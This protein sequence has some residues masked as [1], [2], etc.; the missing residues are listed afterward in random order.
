MVSQETVEARLKSFLG[1]LQA[2]YGILDRIVYKNKNQHRRCSYFQYLLKVRSDLRL[3]Q[4]AHLEEIVSSSFIV[5]NGNRAKQK[6]Q[7]LESLK[8]KKC[9]GKHNFLERLLGATRLVAEMVEP[10]MKAATEISILLARSFFMSFSVTVLALLGRLRV[11]VQQILLDV[12]SVFNTVST[13]SQ[14]AQSVKLSQE[15]FEVYREY[16]PT[17]EQTVTLD[18]VL[19]T[20][21]FVLLER[22]NEPS[23]KDSD[24]DTREEVSLGRPAVQYQSIETVL[25]DDLSKPSEEN[26]ANLK[27]DDTTTTTA[28]N[29]SSLEATVPQSDDSKQKDED[30]YKVENNSGLRIGPPGPE[31]NWMTSS[32]LSLPLKRKSGLGGKVAFVSVKRPAPSTVKEKGVVENP[33]EI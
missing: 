13:L 23:N 20:N 24:A 18:C 30:G 5:I 17:L 15:G 22:I 19:E 3:L 8:R 7:L 27:E 21:K 16:Y 25:G 14:K 28:T 11:L 4:S 32:T 26:P 2:E 1:Q 31:D 9:D 6:V 29:T 12:V 33:E 10:M